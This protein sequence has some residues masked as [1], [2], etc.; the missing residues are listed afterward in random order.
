MFNQS[1][2][3]TA[4]FRSLVEKAGTLQTELVS[5]DT[6]VR[7][8]DAIKARMGDCRDEAEARTFVGELTRAEQTVTVKRIREPRL[9]AEMAEVVKEAEIALHN[10]LTE[11]GDILTE[12]GEFAMRAIRDLLQSIQPE[13][14]N[15]KRD[16]ANEV[17]LAAVGP[18]V[19][20]ARLQQDVGGAWRGIGVVTSDPYGPVNAIKS[21]L[22]IVEQII[23]TLPQI[24]AEGQRYASACEVF[25]K[26]LAKG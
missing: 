14:E 8:L 18:A 12:R 22:V 19:L 25:R 15:R 10:A 26:V 7:D 9:R 13:E 4:A 5:L 20:V 6:A 3:K 16:D 21:S 17:T 1:T 2:P 23:G 24:Q 11:L